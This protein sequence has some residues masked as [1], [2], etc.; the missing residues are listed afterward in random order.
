[1]FEGFEAGSQIMVELSTEAERVAGVLTGV[2]DSGIYMLVTHR[3]GVREPY[4]AEEIT[5]MEK[6]VRAIV[7]NTPTV[8]LRMSALGARGLFGMQWNR[9]KLIESVTKEQ[10]SL[11]IEK[12]ES[13]LYLKKALA[14]VRT[15]LNGGTI[16]RIEILSDLNEDSILSGLDFAP[17]EE[18]K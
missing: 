4:T 18:V 5:E 10:V 14:P 2:D 17:E 16:D 9:E 7:E 8:H 11:V 13:E 15:F 6:L 3:M 1:M 12:T